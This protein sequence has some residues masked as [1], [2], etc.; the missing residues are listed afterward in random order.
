[1]PTVGEVIPRRWTRP[2]LAAVSLALLAGCSSAPQDDAAEGWSPPPPAAPGVGR[3]EPAPQVGCTAQVTDAGALR[4]AIA[5]AAPGDRLCVRGD[6][7]GSRVLIDR[8]GTPQ[9]PITLLGGGRTT[10]GGISV[11]ADHVIVDGFASVRAQAPG[12]LLRGDGLTL[13]NSTVQS[14]RGGDGDGV[15]FFG[16][17]IQ[18]VRNTI[19]DTVG[20][21]ERHADC[22]QTYATDERHPASSQVL[23]EGN[24]CED[25]DNICVIAEGPNSEAGDGSGEGRARQFVVRDNVCDNGAGQA[26][27]FDDVSQVVVTGNRVVGPVDKAFSFQNG[28]VGALVE[29][30][31]LAP[32]VGYEVGIDES[33]RRGYRGPEPGGRP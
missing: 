12:V 26:L 32:G 6:L 19:S 4:A 23:I 2:A 29:G 28:S 24:L 27:F 5:G 21:T 30:N 20:R 9:R 1:V 3:G 33:S 16:T 14:P 8:S 7:S 25:I 17:G 15:R 22:M 31:S 10:V 13:R 18:I 11:E